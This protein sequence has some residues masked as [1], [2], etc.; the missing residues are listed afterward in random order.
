MGIDYSANA[1]IGYE[2]ELSIAL[3]VSDDHIQ[4][5]IEENL[6]NGFNYFVNEN[7]Y[8]NEVGTTFVC[9]DDNTIDIMDS[10]SVAAAKFRLDAELERIKL[11]TISDFGVQCGLYIF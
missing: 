5:Y 8:N 4:D 3:D 11:V 1:G 7:A 10:K 6:G 9:V 2:V